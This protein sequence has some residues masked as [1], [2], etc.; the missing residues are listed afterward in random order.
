MEGLDPGVADGGAG[1]A[2]GPRLL[3][4]GPQHTRRPCGRVL[5]VGDL[6]LAVEEVVD[7]NVGH[8]ARLDEAIVE[9]RVRV[10]DRQR[11]DGATRASDPARI[12]PG[13]LWPARG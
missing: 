5:P 4:L 12:P 9:T 8:R 1:Q 10:R 6:L 13:A 7:G 11:R 3:R 2:C